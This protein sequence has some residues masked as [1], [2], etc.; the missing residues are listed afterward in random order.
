MESIP[1]LNRLMLKP[2]SAAESSPIDGK[3]V[4]EQPVIAVGDWG[5]A[6]TL[7]R[8]GG[9]AQ[10]GDQMLDVVSDGAFLQPGVQVRIVDLHG[11]RIVVERRGLADRRRN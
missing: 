1:M 11:T 3:S 7:L 10:F 2:P 5:V 9:K 4:P 6:A 8:P